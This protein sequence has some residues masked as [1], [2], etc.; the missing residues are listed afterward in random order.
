[1][2]DAGRG[3]RSEYAHGHPKSEAREPFAHRAASGSVA[4]RAASR[5]C[6]HYWAD[7]R[8]PLSSVLEPGR[9]LLVLLEEGLRQ[10]FGS[11][12]LR[13]R[14]PLLPLGPFP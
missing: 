1:M 11:L 12:D 5:Q 9:A 8:A 13:R 3:I 6:H 4:L 14:G 10:L 7:V 2:W